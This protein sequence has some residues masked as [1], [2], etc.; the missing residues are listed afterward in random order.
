[1]KGLF[2]TKTNLVLAELVIEPIVIVDK[3]GEDFHGFPGD[4]Q[5][6]DTNGYTY[7]LSKYAFAAL[8]QPKDANSF[9]LLHK[10]N[11]KKKKKK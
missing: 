7:F 4:W 11:L 5:I 8:Y 10:S 9:S 3:N 6:W 1:M 2:E